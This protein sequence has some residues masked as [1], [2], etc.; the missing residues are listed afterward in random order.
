MVA[1]KLKVF[2]EYVPRAEY[3]PLICSL[4]PRLFLCIALVTVP[5]SVKNF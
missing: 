4:V 1:N 5:I 3:S 2:E